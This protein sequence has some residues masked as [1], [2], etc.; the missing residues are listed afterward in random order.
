M[1]TLRLSLAGTVSLVLLGGL[2]GA[3][4]AQSDEAAVV[5]TGTE[6]C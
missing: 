1:R 3:V 2:G 5:V 6:S 4:A